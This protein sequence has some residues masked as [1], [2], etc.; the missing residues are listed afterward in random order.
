MEEKM[1]DKERK[2]YIAN[3]A[4]A[5]MNLAQ[6]P[7]IDRAKICYFADATIQLAEKS[8]G[9]IENNI[10]QFKSILFEAKEINNRRA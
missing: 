10:E 6:Q 1:T 8:D 7:K 2:V 5:I 9:W 3:I 4:V